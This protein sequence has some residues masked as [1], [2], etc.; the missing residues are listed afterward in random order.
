MTRD[1]LDPGPDGTYP[2]WPRTPDGKWDTV[3]MPVGL[4]RQRVAGSTE[5]IMVDLTPRHPDGSVICPPDLEVP[6]GIE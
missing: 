2:A 5:V 4:Q 3:R 1:A 6:D